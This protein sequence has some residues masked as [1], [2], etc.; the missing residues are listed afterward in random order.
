MTERLAKANKAWNEAIKTRSIFMKKAEENAEH[1]YYKDSCD[2][3]TGCNVIDLEKTFSP[4]II[5]EY[6]RLRKVV[7][8]AYAEVVEAEKEE[9]RLKKEAKIKRDLE[10][11]ITPEIRKA[12]TNYRRIEREIKQAQERIAELQEFIAESE[13]KQDGKI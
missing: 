4:E 3:Y 1:I 11:G 2:Y 7:S 9:K 5:A 13:N 8:D 6:Y 10:K 12:I